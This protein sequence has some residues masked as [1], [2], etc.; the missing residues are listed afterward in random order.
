LLA[1]FGF[2]VGLFPIH[3]ASIRTET[4]PAKNIFHLVAEFITAVALLVGGWGL[5]KDK[6]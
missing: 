2:A 5:L 3:K 4:E 1:F 6:A